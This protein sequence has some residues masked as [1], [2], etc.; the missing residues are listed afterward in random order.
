MGEDMFWEKRMLAQGHHQ[1]PVLVFGGTLVQQRESNPL[2]STPSGSPIKDALADIT[3][4]KTR[5]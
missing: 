5:N 2:L 1:I 4:Q 3:R